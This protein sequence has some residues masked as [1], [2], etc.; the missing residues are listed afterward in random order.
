MPRPTAGISLSLLFPPATRCPT[1]RFN[2]HQHPTALPLSGAASRNLPPFL[3]LT[4]STHRPP[5][6]FI[7]LSRPTPIPSSLTPAWTVIRLHRDRLVSCVSP[8]GSCNL[9]PSIFLRLSV[10]SPS[11]S[12]HL[13]PW[14]FSLPFSVSSL[15]SHLTHELSD[16]SPELD[17][18]PSLAPEAL[19]RLSLALEPTNASSEVN[20]NNSS[21]VFNAREVGVVGDV[22]TDNTQAFR[23]HGK[24]LA[25]LN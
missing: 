11:L 19:S 22:M 1:S 18:E 24:K 8:S 20:T 13:W 7:P 12:L 9:D 17:L 14:F 3:H 10:S 15:L 5:S 4:P 23:E 25:R 16:L 6:P 21:K 2:Y